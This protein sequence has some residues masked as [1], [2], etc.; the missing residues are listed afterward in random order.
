MQQNCSN[1]LNVLIYSNK[2]YRSEQ[3]WCFRGTSFTWN[4]WR[5]TM[6]NRRI[7]KLYLRP[8][9]SFWTRPSDSAL[10]RI[11]LSTRLLV[12]LRCS[13]TL[14][15]LGRCSRCTLAFVSSCKYSP[16][17]K[18][19]DMRSCPKI[20]TLSA[21][22]WLVSVVFWSRSIKSQV[23]R[24]CKICLQWRYFNAKSTYLP[25]SRRSPMLEGCERRIW[26]H[27]WFKDLTFILDHI[28]SL[29]DH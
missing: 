24:I 20:D 13:P 3:A 29:F 18:M 16:E 12:L 28:D 27:G 10:M 1:S 11:G 17:R 14:Y 7:P 26:F 21:L 23:L 6:A 4:V 15:I 5:A 2:K 8:T 22:C 19:S 9:M 25:L